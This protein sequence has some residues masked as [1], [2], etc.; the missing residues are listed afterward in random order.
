MRACI[1]T[2][3]S[4]VATGHL[5]AVAKRSVVIAVALDTVTPD[6]L[7]YGQE[8]GAGKVI[9]CLEQRIHAHRVRRR[10]IRGALGLL[11][12]A[13][14]RLHRLRQRQEE[15]TS[16][17]YSAVSRQACSATVRFPTQRTQ[18]TANHPALL[19]G[20]PDTTIDVVHALSL[21]R[22]SKMRPRAQRGARNDQAL[23]ARAVTCSREP[24]L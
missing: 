23:G 5:D 9:C 14:R 16:S 7:T 21:N 12:L 1:R 2:H 4:V 3:G 18:L 13:V 10:S 24:S 17:Q 19:G 22:T 8:T 20:T 11:G 6:R 15:E